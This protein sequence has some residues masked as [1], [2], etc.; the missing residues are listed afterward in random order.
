[1]IPEGETKEAKPTAMRPITVLATLWRVYAKIRAKQLL[2]WISTWA[3][4]AN[5]GG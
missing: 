3:S 1:M 4:D 5:R 2:D